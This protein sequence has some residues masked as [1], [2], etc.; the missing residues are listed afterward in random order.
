MT[1]LERH[2]KVSVILLSS[3]LSSTVGFYYPPCYSFSFHL[4]ILTEQTFKFTKV[5]CTSKIYVFWPSY[6]YSSN[7]LTSSD[8]PIFTYQIYSRFLTLLFSLIKYTHVF[9]F[10]FHSFNA[11][12]FRLTFF[13]SHIL[14]FSDLTI[15][16]HHTHVFKPYYF[17]SSI[18]L[19]FSN[20][21]LNKHIYK[22]SL[23]S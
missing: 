3:Y 5:Q 7:I 18:I 9:W 2:S 8:L 21:S 14:T 22:C 20:L 4:A 13:L 6:F 15:F 17:H 12:V 23:N 16:T 19:K 11:R 1:I 10:Y